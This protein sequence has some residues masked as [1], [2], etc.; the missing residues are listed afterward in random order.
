MLCK[1]LVYGTDWFIVQF[2][3]YVYLLIF[4]CLDYPFI[5]ET[6]LLKFQ[7]ITILDLVFLELMFI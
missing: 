2:N 7:A 6:K 1:C 3:Y 4:F 5:D